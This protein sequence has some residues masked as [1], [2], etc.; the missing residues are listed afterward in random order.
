MAPPAIT[1]IGPV[2]ASARP[3]SAT[4]GPVPDRAPADG[5]ASALQAQ[6][7]MGNAALAAM[8]SAPPGGYPPGLPPDA[9]GRALLAGQALLSGQRSLAA[10]GMVGNGAVAVAGGL[11]A[12]APASDAAGP[13]LLTRQGM[14]GNGAVA[15]AGGPA[16]TAPGRSVPLPPAASL[17]VPGVPAPAPVLRPA[18]VAGGAS[19]RAGGAPGPVP[20]AATAGPVAVGGALTAGEPVAVAGAPAAEAAGGGPATVPRPGPGKDPKFAK[21]KKDVHAKKRAVAASHPPAAAESGAA[22]AAAR[23]PADDK[24]AQGKA[25]NA[26]KMDAAKPGEFDKAAFIAAVEQAIARRAPQNLEQ[27]DEFADSG[28]ADEVRKDVQGRVGEGRQ[29]AAAD[30]ATT[31]AAPPDTSRATE[32]QVVPLTADRPPPTPQTPDPTGAVPDPLP[33]SATDLSAGPQQVNQQLADAQVTEPQLAHSNEPQFINTLNH[34]RAA[35]QDSVRAQTAMRAHEVKTLAATKADAQHLGATAMHAIGGKRVS[36]GKQV[37]AGKTGAKDSDETKRAQVTATLQ[38]VFDTT[39]KD[40]E[41]ILSGLDK[42]V[43]DQFDR[44]EKRARDAFTAEHKRRMEEYKDKRYSG[45]TGKARWLK[46]KLLG[47]PKEA[48]RIFV[49]ARDHYVTQMRRVISDV[50]DT[51]ATELARAKQRIAKGRADLQAEVTRLPADLQAIGKQAASDFAG[52]FDELRQS[53]DDKGT[54]LVDTLATKYTDAL[55]SI[56]EEVA[57]EKEKNKGLIDK[58]KDAVGGVIKTILELKNLL[59]GVLRKAAQAVTGILKDPIGFLRNLVSA[60]GTG[61]KQFIKNIGTHLQQGLLGWLLGAMSSAGLALPAKFDLRGIITL[62]ASL[63]GLTWGAIR[64]RIVSRGVPEPAIAAAEKS[65]PVAQKLQSEGVA[66]IWQEIAAKVGD[67]R[68]N[69]F[70]KITE[71]LIPTV[72]IAG[73]TWIISL[74]NPASAFVKACKMIIDIVTFI[75]ERGAQIIAF[76]NAVLDAVIAIATGGTGG[77]PALIEK[78]LAMSIPVLIGALA[79]ILG[80]SG[81]AEKVKKFFQSLSKPVMKAVDWIVDK[82]VNL[83]KKLWSKLKS[84][85]GKHNAGAAEPDARSNKEKLRALK[86]A[87]GEVE[88]IAGDAPERRGLQKRLAAIQARHHLTR[89]FLENLPGNSFRVVAEINPRWPSKVYPSGETKYT[90]TENGER[91]LRPR[92]RGAQMIRRRL[93]SS[94]NRGPTQRIIWDRVTPLLRQKN[95]ITNEW[96]VTS[97]R[98]KAGFWE[99]TPGQV[100]SLADERTKPTLSHNP[101]VVTHWN[102]TGNNASQS[103]RIAFYHFQGKEKTAQVVMFY[104]NRDEGA[105]GEAEYTHKV[106]PNF[107]EPGE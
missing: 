104:L 101:P 28:K 105:G 41:N 77:V 70:G 44:E 86:A 83:A 107:T 92:Y 8:L 78:A 3:A 96:E 18:A 43:D 33:P 7:L 50:A 90:I 51:I 93:Y 21:L 48:D 91:V 13:G 2:V 31:T 37:G 9:A 22:Q 98:E 11:T 34:K 40:V 59:L 56:D 79:A 19:V 95:Q 97:D 32:K 26:E 94:S 87:V 4:V 39:K 36:T 57:A 5:V 16:A 60:V 42:K 106:G 30:I 75:V 63:L 55:K 23:P 89:L 53:V 38:K 35:E 14:V 72:L 24:E 46:D 71:Y 62:I 74:L 47:L 66:G 81:I 99:P 15:V 76:V 20:A 64:G 52:K 49:E 65:V 69:L 67:L 61:L 82:I 73:I 58:A 1:D 12:R 84:K 17:L 10:Q 102:S 27:A 80:I 88:V 45:W 103:D 6:F 29:A 54:E 100:V 25:A 85:F 68:A